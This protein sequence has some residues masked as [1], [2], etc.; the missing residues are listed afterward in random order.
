VRRIVFLS[1]E[2]LFEVCFCFLLVF[3]LYFGCSL[4]SSFL[5]VIHWGSL[6]LSSKKDDLGVRR[7]FNVFHL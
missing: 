3:L 2:S 6:L 7:C 1:L 4:L 5:A